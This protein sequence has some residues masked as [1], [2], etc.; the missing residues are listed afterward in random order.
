MEKV[1]FIDV[2][3]RYRNGERDFSGTDMQNAAKAGLDLKGIIFRGSD[4]SGTNFSNSELSNADF[5]DCNLGRCL[6]DN[7]VLRSASFEGA[8]LSRASMRGVVIDRTV[9]RK[10]NFMWAHLCGNDLMKA[11]LADA[12]LDWSCLIGTQV[13]DD[14]AQAIPQAALLTRTGKHEGQQMQPGGNYGYPNLQAKGGY[15]QAQSGQGYG[16]G[17]QPQ[18]GSYV[19]GSGEYREEQREDLSLPAPLRKKKQED[20]EY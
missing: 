2:I 10:A 9:F 16:G 5:S 12:V 11:D 17:T 18:Q 7:A 13:T 19:L 15:G 8:N 3:A 14:Q 4:L 6:F 20:K 1:S